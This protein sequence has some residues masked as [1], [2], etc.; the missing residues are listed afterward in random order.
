MVQK[1]LRDERNEK[2]KELENKRK[3][4]TDNRGDYSFYYAI[5]RGKVVEIPKEKSKSKPESD[6]NKVN[7]KEEGGEHKQPNQ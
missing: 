7:E 2:N 5:R 6:E 3:A 1:Q 4:D